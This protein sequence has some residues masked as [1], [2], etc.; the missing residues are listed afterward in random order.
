MNGYHFSW[1][2]PPL[3]ERGREREHI[4]DE[5]WL[6]TDEA[7]CCRPPQFNGLGVH[8]LALHVHVASQNRERERERVA[9]P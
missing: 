2:V 7:W 8:E 5:K 9:Y 1:F 6:H 3:G 4:Y